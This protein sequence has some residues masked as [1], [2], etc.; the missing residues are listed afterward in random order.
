MGGQTDSQVGFQVHAS[1]KK[2]NR[3][4]VQMW[5]QIQMWPNGGPTVKN[6]RRL[7]YEFELN[8]VN[9]GQRKWVAKRNTSESVASTCESLK[10][11]T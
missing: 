7:V 6:L 2:V 8:Q 11:R 3:Y 10:I 9:V 4:I 5:I 1:R